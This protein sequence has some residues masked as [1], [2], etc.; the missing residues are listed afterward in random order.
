V[1]ST[2]GPLSDTVNANGNLVARGSDTFA[3]DQANRL[4][5]A[6]VGG[7]ASTNVYDGDGKRAS[8]TVGST[9]T[10]YAYDVNTAL[11]NVLTDGTLKY[12]FGLGLT[13]AVD[14]SG[15]V[16]VYHVDG[17]GS[18]RVLTDGNGNVIQIY[19][20][21]AFGN[22]TQ[23]QGSST[24]PFQYTGQQRD[25][26]TGLYYLRAR[27]YD[28]TTGRFVSRDPFP[29]TLRSPLSLNRYT[30]VH[31]NP[32]A[33]VDPAGHAIS[34]LLDNDC[35]TTAGGAFVGYLVSARCLDFPLYTVVVGQVRVAPNGPTVTV[36][37][38]L[39]TNPPHDNGDDTGDNSEQEIPAT[40]HGTQ[41]LHEQGWTYAQYLFVKAGTVL[42]QTDGA[43]V[44]IRK[45]GRNSYNV[46]VEGSE[47]VITAFKGLSRHELRNLATNYGWH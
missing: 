28:P 32:T 21:D 43:L 31:N 22:P 2:S 15:T 16:Q 8:T 14:R 36:T 4:I 44:Y 46:I 6:T 5:S 38:L 39:A 24:Q 35:F 19:Q 47:G 12:V 34:K 25:A 42:E 9:T 23:T 33:F 27:M 18:V 17:L 26:S 41:R 3:Y 10:S 29:G 20:T 1:V 30:Y 11:P 7:T 40:E 37:L 13:Y 45:V